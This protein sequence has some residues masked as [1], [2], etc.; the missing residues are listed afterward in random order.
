MYNHYTELYRRS[1]KWL[2]SGIH[3]YTH[4]HTP[5]VREK[6]LRNKLKG[7]KEMIY[8][9]IHQLRTVSRLILLSA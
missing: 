4:T 8:D 6:E 2:S 9:E 1:D 5:C 7:E 3:I